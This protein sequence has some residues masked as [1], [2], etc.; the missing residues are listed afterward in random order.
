MHI[1]KNINSYPTTHIKVL[2]LTF[3]YFS[4]AKVSAVVNTLNKKFNILY[5]LYIA[6]KQTQIVIRNKLITKF[7]K[8]LILF[9]I[10]IKK[11]ICEDFNKYKN[12]KL[13]GFILMFTR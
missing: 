6:S 13:L 10:S 8:K 5:T 11:H 9:L 1:D 3:S 4:L 2:I 12:K 7:N